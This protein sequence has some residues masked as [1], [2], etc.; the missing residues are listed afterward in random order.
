MQHKSF[1]PSR[2]IDAGGRVASSGTLVAEPSFPGHSTRLACQ[3]STTQVRP[4]I[5][6]TQLVLSS[7][8][9]GTPHLR[10][11]QSARR[12]RGHARGARSRASRS[13]P[14]AGAVRAPH[15]HRRATRACRYPTTCLAQSRARRVAP[16]RRPAA[17]PAPCGHARRLDQP[18]SHRVRI[19][20]CRG[21]AAQGGLTGHRQVHLDEPSTT[22]SSVIPGFVPEAQSGRV[23]AVRHLSRAAGPGRPRHARPP[24]R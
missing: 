11:P 17:R 16:G 3:S 19:L 6:P 7:R 12:E 4:W 15:A 5:T 24:R 22:G 23:P 20:P 14:G 21:G 1:T 13:L 10:A 2:P 18:R 9:T 8:P